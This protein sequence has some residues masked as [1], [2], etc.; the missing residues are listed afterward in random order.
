MC[1]TLVSEHAWNRERPDFCS[2]S[3]GLQT[4]TTA[5]VTGV[6]A[7][8]TTVTAT[9]PGGQVVSQIQVQNVNLSFVP[10]SATFFAGPNYAQSV[11]VIMSVAALA[12]GQTVNLSSSDTTVATV[13]ASIIIPSGSTTVNVTITGVGPGAATITASSPGLNSGTYSA[14]VVAPTAL[15]DNLETARSTYTGVR[16]HSTRSTFRI[17]LQSAAFR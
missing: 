13:P 10:G 9:A 17:L 5:V 14:T 15:V 2:D 7:G 8:N 6:S 16:T 11:T 1:I 12:G 4:Q 3:G